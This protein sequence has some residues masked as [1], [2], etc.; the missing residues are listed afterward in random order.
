MLMTEARWRQYDGLAKYKPLVNVSIDSC[1]P[2]VYEVLRR[3]GKWDRLAPNLAFLGRE[4]A[5]GT[6]REYH[7]NATIQLDNYHEMPAL[8]DYAEHVG[9]DSVRL[10]MM[11]NTGDHIASWYSSK[12]VG[13]PAHPLHSA[14]LETLRD[15]RLGRASAHLYD[16]AAWRARALE[17]QVPTDALGADYTREALGEAIAAALVESAHDRVVAL[18]AGGRIHFTGD[19]DLLR[20]EAEALETLGFAQAASYRLREADAIEQAGALQSAA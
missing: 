11:Q 18:C 6:F 3:P 8:V 14:F 12:N 10:Y 7:L 2:W 4:R 19:V 17:T 15:P 5:A 16:V 1:T 13:D 20:I 9:A